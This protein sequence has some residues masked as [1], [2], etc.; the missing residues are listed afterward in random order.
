MI[1]AFEFC[2]FRVWWC[3]KIISSC[4]KQKNLKQ[5]NQQSP[6]PPTTVHQSFH[7]GMNM[8]DMMPMPRSFHHSQ[9]S[10]QY[11]YKRHPM[12]AYV[13]MPQWYLHQVRALPGSYV[14]STP[15]GAKY[16]WNRL[17]RCRRVI[18][19][20]KMPSTT[21]GN[22]CNYRYIHSA[23]TS[24]ESDSPQ[25]QNPLSTDNNK[26][27]SVLNPPKPAINL[28]PK[29]DVPGGDA[30]TSWDSKDYH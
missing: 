16:W 27:G 6:K 10:S 22:K 30:I 26:G 21:K 5:L 9:P 8:L 7:G 20:E 18:L 2:Y 12:S 23:G 15:D 17:M 25:V 28:V 13:N 1:S 14:T 19:E 4:R 11:V 29:K 3:R 24:G